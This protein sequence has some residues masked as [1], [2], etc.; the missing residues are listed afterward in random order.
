MIRL[1]RPR[2]SRQGCGPV[3]SRHTVGT[4]G[5]LTLHDL[6]RQGSF[7]AGAVD[8]GR[9]RFGRATASRLRAALVRGWPAPVNHNEGPLVYVTVGLRTKLSPPA[10]TEEIP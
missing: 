1:H 2:R 5:C 6:P 10:P 3:N 4:Q 7:T 9:D 8:A